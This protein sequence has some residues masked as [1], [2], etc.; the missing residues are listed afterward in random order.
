MCALKRA[1]S[2][3]VIWASATS[4][5]CFVVFGFFSEGRVRRRCQYHVHLSYWIFQ[6]PRE[7][8][9][10]ITPTVDAVHHTFIQQFSFFVQVCFARVFLPE[11]SLRVP[12]APQPP[13][14]LCGGCDNLPSWAAGARDVWV[15]RCKPLSLPIQ[16]RPL[17]LPSFQRWNSRAAFDEDAVLASAATPINA[18]VWMDATM[19]LMH[20]DARSDSVL[21]RSILSFVSRSRW[22]CVEVCS[23]WQF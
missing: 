2:L 11:A 7:L 6:V 19:H 22:L 1:K 18:G 3:L 20:V 14:C 10:H 5:C 21:H 8:S 15:R 4:S 17:T 13:A 12:H 23:N 9:N 16:V